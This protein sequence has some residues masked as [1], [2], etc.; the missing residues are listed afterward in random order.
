[1][2][3]IKLMG[4]KI[5]AANISFKATEDEIRD[6]F[7][8]FG[9]VESINII[10]E[11]RTGRPKGFCFIELASEEDAK[12]AIE[13]LNG[14]I[15]ME[16][17]LTVAEARPQQPREKRDFDSGGDGFRGNGRGPGRGRR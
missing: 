2:K 5:Y 1:M 9:K 4:K 6:L 11:A 13:S 10:T 16:R 17:T 15:F 3:G 8:P 7:S 12:K 14:S